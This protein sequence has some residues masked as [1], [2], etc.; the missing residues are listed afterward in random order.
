MRQDTA[1]SAHTAHIAGR[2]ALIAQGPGQARGA[3]AR[4]T[5]RGPRPE[6]RLS[7]AARPGKPWRACVRAGVVKGVAPACAGL[8]LGRA[9]PPA[10]QAGA[11]RP[12]LPTPPASW[13]LRVPTRNGVAAAA[14]AAAAGRVVVANITDRPVLE[15]CKQ[16]SVTRN[17]SCKG[18]RHWT[19]T[20]F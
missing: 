1:L 4:L 11:P 7:A 20:T 8:R 3:E 15:L 14:A 12:A 16:E 5:A 6:A 9:E 10:G 2:P 18:S 17:L 19:V 13:R